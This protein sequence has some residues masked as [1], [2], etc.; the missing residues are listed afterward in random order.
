MPPAT[1]PAP[2]AT[3]DSELAPDGLSLTNDGRIF[4]TTA[5]PL[6]ER[7]GDQRKDVYEWEAQ[8][9][10][11]AEGSYNCSDADG[12][13]DLISTGSSPYD[14]DPARG[15]RQRHRRLLLYPRQACPPRRKRKYRQDL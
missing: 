11:E 2:N 9:T 15:K 3:A 4:F 13:V 10:S 6:V 5:E 7:D 8:G 14:C 1:R 12:C